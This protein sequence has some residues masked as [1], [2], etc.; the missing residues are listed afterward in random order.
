MAS[1][2]VHVINHLQIN[3]VMVKWPIVKI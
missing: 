2:S 1:S 3:E